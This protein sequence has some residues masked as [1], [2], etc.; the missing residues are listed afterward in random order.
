MNKL[1]KY[2]DSL[3]AATK[4][5]YKQKISL[6]G[7]DPFVINEMATPQRLT[8][9]SPSAVTGQWAIPLTILPLIDSSDLVSYLVLQTSF[10]TAKQFKDH[11]SMEGY[12]QFV[13]SWVKDVN[14]W[15]VSSKMHYYLEGQCMIA[16]VKFNKYIIIYLLFS[17]GT[18]LPVLSRSP[19]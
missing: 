8:T 11:K 18:S 3:P 4:D 9:V 12:N 5:R 16:C 14:A 19:T 1:S 15:S 10:V 17:I 6:I 13:C 2:A 7:I